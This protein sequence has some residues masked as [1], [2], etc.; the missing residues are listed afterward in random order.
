M[1]P[2]WMS[3]VLAIC[4]LLSLN[5][6]AGNEPNLTIGGLNESFN[7]SNMLE[8]RTYM[9]RSQ[10][11][12]ETL[13][14]KNIGD[15]DFKEAI[16]VNLG[17][18]SIMKKKTLKPGES[19]KI[20]LRKEVKP[21]VYDIEILPTGEMF[22]RALISKSNFYYYLSYWKQALLIL[23]LI[24]VLYKFIRSRPVKEDEYIEIKED[25]RKFIIESTKKP[26]FK[27]GKK[28]KEEFIIVSKGDKPKPPEEGGVMG[29]FD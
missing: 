21:G 11:I 24:F 9:L 14:I 23:F 15:V 5:V 3:G 29:M 19:I 26:K 12:N 7:A 20:N 16:T 10:L 8:N 28:A 22:E 6:R 4:I 25:K 27:F 18:Y 1:K 17:D 13:E 2:V